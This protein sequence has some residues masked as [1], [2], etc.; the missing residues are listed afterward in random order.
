MGN[1]LK[2]CMVAEGKANIYP[3]L[4]PTLEWDNPGLYAVVIAAGGKV[5]DIHNKPSLYN[6]MSSIRNPYFV[7]IG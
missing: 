6:A 7:V 2:F 5:S 3:R 4:G 1:S